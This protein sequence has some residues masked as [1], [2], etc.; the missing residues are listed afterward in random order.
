MKLYT[1]YKTLLQVSGTIVMS[2]ALLF[3]RVGKNPKI[4]HQLYSN[5]L[6]ACVWER[7]GGEGERFISYILEL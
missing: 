1:I 2:V 6:C 5:I 3:N 7:E 4:Q